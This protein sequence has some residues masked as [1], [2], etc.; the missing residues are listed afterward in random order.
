[1][2]FICVA[3]VVLFQKVLFIIHSAYPAFGYL[4]YISAKKTTPKFSSNFLFQ[5]SPAI[6]FF[7]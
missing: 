5:Q 4:R 7:V 6:K 2:Q 1:M 3:A